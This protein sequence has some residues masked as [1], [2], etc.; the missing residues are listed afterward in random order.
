M[1]LV[2]RLLRENE[3]DDS[4]NSDR[5][6]GPPTREIGVN[7]DDDQ[8]EAKVCDPEETRK[9]ESSRFNLHLESSN[10]PFQSFSSARFQV[11]RTTILSKR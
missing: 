6:E 1:P 3:D 11:T 10:H 7:T 8:Q 4:N 9:H 2:H 5:M